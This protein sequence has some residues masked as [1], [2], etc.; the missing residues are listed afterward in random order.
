MIRKRV[1]YTAV[2]MAALLSISTGCGSKSESLHD[3]SSVT[4]VMIPL[5]MPDINFTVP[6]GFVSDSSEY[7]SQFYVRDDASIIINS[8]KFTEQYST[9]DE[10]ADYALTVYES[11]CSRMTVNSREKIDVNGIEMTLIE[12]T[13]EIDSENGTLSMTNMVGFF[14]DEECPYLITC[15]SLT[16]TYEANRSDFLNTVKSISFK[17]S[18]EK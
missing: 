7:N 1:I 5:R 17:A 4:E 11:Y 3:E 12:Y 15:K 14:A 2:L 9:A 8:D 13:Y 10:F 16:D 18:D 6:E